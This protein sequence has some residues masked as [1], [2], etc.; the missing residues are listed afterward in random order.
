M[1]TVVV[2][3]GL[4]LGPRYRY[5]DP[6]DP[7]P[8]A[9]EVRLGSDLEE[10]D[11]DEFKVWTAAFADAERHR[12]L[13]VNR[14]SL[15]RFLVGRG[16]PA[17]PGTVI[18]RLLDRRLLLEFDPI[19]EP[20]E[21]VFRRYQLFP[22]AEGLGSTAEEPHQHRIGHGGQPLI[23]LNITVYSLWSFATTLPS[24]WDACVYFAADVDADD[25][26][27][28]DLDDF[29]ELSAEEAAR[30]IGASIPMLVAAG[31][32]FLDPVGEP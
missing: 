29:D 12:N 21:D 6:P 23:A 13:L 19:E 25:L 26:D 27:E 24:L 31:C 20:L 15:E 28:L 17:D 16:A 1:P 3:I 7:D 8:E 32:A 18:D 5:V 11:A 9:Y 22:L 2:P 4:N 30:E 10:L 14:A